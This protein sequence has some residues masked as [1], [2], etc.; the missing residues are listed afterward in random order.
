MISNINGPQMNIYLRHPDHG[1]KIA[2][3]ELEAEA[4]E[5]NGWQRF[6]PETPDDQPNAMRR[7]GRPRVVKELDDARYSPR[8]NL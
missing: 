4:D 8:D 2:T 3:M 1:V 7:R 6:D 5:E